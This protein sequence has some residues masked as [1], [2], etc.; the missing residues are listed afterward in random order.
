MDIAA[1]LALTLKGIE[2]IETLVAV[3]Q[4]I[5]PAVKVITDMITGAQ[6]GTVTDEQLLSTEDALDAMI[7]DFN[8][9]MDDA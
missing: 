8:K 7:E 4:D 1:I 9:P 6:A 3:G 2:V 5:A